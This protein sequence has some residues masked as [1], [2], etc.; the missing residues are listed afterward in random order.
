MNGDPVEVISHHYTYAMSA[1]R[2]PSDFM[3]A[4]E[5][6][7]RDQRVIF[8]FGFGASSYIC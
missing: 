2:A 3:W 7:F 8:L 6:Y 1:L 5:I 4:A